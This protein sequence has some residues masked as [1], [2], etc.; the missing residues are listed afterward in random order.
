[1]FLN[2]LLSILTIIIL[3]LSF[4]FIF[5]IFEALD[6]NQSEYSESERCELHQR[7]RKRWTNIF[8]RKIFGEKII[9][10]IFLEDYRLLSALILVSL[11]VIF[12]VTFLVQNFDAFLFLQKFALI[13]TS[14]FFVVT[15]TS[16][17]KI[18]YISLFFIVLG[19]IF[20][21]FIIKKEYIVY[22]PIISASRK[23]RD[24]EVNVKHLKDCFALDVLPNTDCSLFNTQCLEEE[25]GEISSEDQIKYNVPPF[26]FS[27]RFNDG[28]IFFDSVEYYDDYGSVYDSDNIVIISF[29]NNN[30]YNILNKDLANII[31]YSGEKIRVIKVSGRPDVDDD[32]SNFYFEIR[33]KDN[34]V[35]KVIINED[36]Y[37]LR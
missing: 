15:I 27:S 4:I 35:E 22:D 5:N 2:F 36:N 34:N 28:F 13:F 6:E 8:L 12:F 26:P 23:G 9:N 11:F 19:F 25:F 31:R 18:L 20:N 32:F 30:I 7:N 16:K 37:F 1:M 10:F 14:L 17:R 3:G 33:V 24:L 21:P 29:D